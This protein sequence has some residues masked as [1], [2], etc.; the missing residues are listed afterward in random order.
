MNRFL[1]LESVRTAL[2]SF[3]SS[4]GRPSVDPELMMRM[5]IVS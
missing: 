3:Y 2:K 4:I 5:L 1:D